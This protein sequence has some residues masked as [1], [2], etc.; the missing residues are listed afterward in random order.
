MF[1]LGDG[2]RIGPVVRQIWAGVDS[3]VPTKKARTISVPSQTMESNLEIHR[4]GIS[5]APQQ[6]DLRQKWLSETTLCGDS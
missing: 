4:W 6:R 5:L 1:S 2:L 3:L